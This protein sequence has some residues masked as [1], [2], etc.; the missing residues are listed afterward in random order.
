MSKFSVEVRQIERIEEHPNADSLELAYLQGLGFQFVVGKG[1]FAPEQKVVYFPID[2]VLP[3]ALRDSLNLAKN[4][5]KA[6][7]LR[8]SFSEGLLVPLAEIGL[9]DNFYVGADLTEHLEVIKYEPPYNGGS[10]ARFSRPDELYTIPVYVYDLEN[11][12]RYPD[13][14]EKLQ[15]VMVVATEKLEGSNWWARL[16]HDFVLGEPQRDCLVEVGQRRF[17]IK[18]GDEA[19]LESP[20]HPWW[21]NFRDQNLD[22]F[23]YQ[24]S[25][26]YRG[27]DITLRGE[28][29]GEGIQ[30]N[31]YG[32]KGRKIFLFDIELDDRPVDAVT[33]HA[34]TRKYDMCAVPTVFIGYMRDLATDATALTAVSSAPSVLNGKLREG[35]VVRPLER[36]MRDPELGRVILKTR[37][38]VYLAGGR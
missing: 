18:A 4:R 11:A 26:E 31:Y 2:A 35:L 17:G 9:G 36:E 28:I 32:L 10:N 34:L 33:F 6:I 8:G 15:N 1:A 23:L 20:Q 19:R 13:V 24:L 14:I 22:N 29:I 7:R 16:S 3:D 12:Q 37:D 21:K 30:G 38:P 25:R 5:I 27:Y